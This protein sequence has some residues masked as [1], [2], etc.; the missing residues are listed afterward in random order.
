M[1]PRMLGPIAAP[2]AAV[3]AVTQTQA[4]VV[5]FVVLPF[6]LAALVIAFVVWRSSGHPPPIRTSVILANGDRA[7]GEVLSVRTLGSHLDL[8]PMVRFSLRV[9]A[10]ADEA[11]FDLEV[12]QS[13]P[14]GAVREFHTGDVV[15]VRVTADRSAGAVVWGGGPPA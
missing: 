1:P 2:L 11:P 14:R 7:R 12:V 5:L 13:L 6:P 3:L 15:E 8:R 10:G 9:S 4:L